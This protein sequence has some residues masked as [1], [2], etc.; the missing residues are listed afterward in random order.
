MKINPKTPSSFGGIYKNWET[1]NKV[2]EGLK[3]KRWLNR[4]KDQLLDY[5]KNLKNDKISEPTRPSDLPIICSIYKVKTIVDFGGSS[6]WLWNYIKAANNDINI[7]KYNIVETK[8]VCNFMKKNKLHT[9]PVI[10]STMKEY[11]ESADVFYC[12]IVIQYFD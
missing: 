7:D 2:G 1:A 10:Y 11:N 3:S 12:N 6:G 4:I 8:E 5:R 9:K